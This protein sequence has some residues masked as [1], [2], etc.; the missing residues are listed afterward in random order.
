MG[1]RLMFAD[2]CHSDQVEKKMREEAGVAGIE[3][4]KLPIDRQIISVGKTFIAL[5][6]GQDY[7]RGCRYECVCCHQLLDQA[8]DILLTFGK[9]R[10]IICCGHLICKKCIEPSQIVQLKSCLKCGDLLQ[11]LQKSRDFTKSDLTNLVVSAIPSGGKGEIDELE[12]VDE[13]GHFTT[14]QDLLRFGPHCQPNNASGSSS[15]QIKTASSSCEKFSSLIGGRVVNVGTNKF[16]LSAEVTKRL[17]VEQ[18]LKVVKGYQCCHCRDKIADTKVYS[19]NIECT[20]HRYCYNCIYPLAWPKGCPGCHYDSLNSTGS[21]KETK[22]K[23]EFK[24]SAAQDFMLGNFHIASGSS[25]SHSSKS[26]GA[27]NRLERIHRVPNSLQILCGCGEILSDANREQDQRYHHCSRLIGTIPPFQEVEGIITA[28][29]ITNV[30]VKQLTSLGV[31]IIDQIDEKC[32]NA[33]VHY[34]HSFQHLK[35][36]CSW[37]RSQKMKN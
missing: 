16:L 30:A 9:E 25:A 27:G 19:D 11:H 18:A 8:H 24:T 7:D 31:D 5:K 12:I 36:F 20:K 26:I 33:D 32:E 37:I 21:T 6:P 14:A 13:C 28:K 35:R 1:D 22:S 2:Y 23:F 4:N 34:H 3:W 17:S 29:T 15:S 10:E